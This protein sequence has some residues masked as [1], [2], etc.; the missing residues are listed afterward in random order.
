MDFDKNSETGGTL[1]DFFWIFPVEGP[2]RVPSWFKAL[3]LG[4]GESE[5]FNEN[6]ADAKAESSGSHAESP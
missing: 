1:P 3:S 6:A 4:A 5:P 2:G